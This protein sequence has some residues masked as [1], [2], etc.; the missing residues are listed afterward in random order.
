MESFKVYVSAKEGPSGV[1]TF[2]VER[3]TA[4]AAL[5]FIGND[6]YEKQ[7][8]K[9]DIYVVDEKGERVYFNPAHPLTLSPALTSLTR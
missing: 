6:I 2:N 9:L 4:L 5:D 1:V 8:E 3:P 7:A